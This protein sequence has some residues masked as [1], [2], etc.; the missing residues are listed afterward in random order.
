MSHPLRAHRVRTCP[1]C[2]HAF[3]E[4]EGAATQQCPHCAHEFVPRANARASLATSARA[5]PAGAAAFA[6]RFTRRRYAPLLA[7]WLPALIVDLMGSLALVAYQQA[8]AIPADL[9]SLAR[10]DQLRFLGVALPIFV[11]VY[12]AKLAAFV[13][14]GA[15]VADEVEPGTKHLARLRGRGAQSI[16]LGVALAL[17]YLA[18]LVLLVVPF[19]IFFHW[20]LFAPA[21]LA[22]PGTTIGGA[23]EESR[24]FAKERRTFGFTALVLLLLASLMVVWAIVTSILIT[25]VE[26]LGVANVYADSTIGSIVAWLLAPIVSVMPAS[27]YHLARVAKAQEQQVDVTAPPADRFRTTKCPGCGTLVPY[28]A[29]GQPVDVTCPVCGRT[30][31]VL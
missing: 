18:G 1:K 2:Q 17:M 14:A 30:G 11:V 15:L 27:L 29:T 6:F 3:P 12:G 16:L 13:G 5:D 9:T 25:L 21:A 4:V 23:L 10:A 7:I 26:P 31:R 8:A 22:R 19:V 24:R 28:T 20:F